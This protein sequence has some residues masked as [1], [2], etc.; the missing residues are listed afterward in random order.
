MSDTISIVWVDLETGGTDEHAHQITQIAAV[1]TGPAPEFDEVDWFEQ[2]VILTEGRWTQEALDKQAYSPEAWAEE[3]IPIARAMTDFDEWLRGFTHQR[4]SKRTDRLYDVC[5][6]GGHNVE[7]DGRFLRATA[8]RL[9]LWLP[10]TNW[11]GGQLDT[12]H[13]AKWWFL[14]RHEYPETFTL[15][16]LCEYF[17]IPINAHDAEDDVLATIQ[18][19]RKLAAVTP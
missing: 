7:F 12:L 18:L 19:A 5:H 8:K 14:L 11:T 17:R 4:R 15:E 13:M 6:M 1:A 2:K 3:A 16:A 10:L 9:A